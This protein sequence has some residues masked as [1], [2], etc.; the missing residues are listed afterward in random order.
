[1]SLHVFCASGQTHDS[2]FSTYLMVRP[3]QTPEHSPLKFPKSFT[4]WIFWA[5]MTLHGR[6]F[7]GSSLWSFW[8]FSTAPWSSVRRLKGRNCETIALLGEN[9]KEGREGGKGWGKRQLSQDWQTFINVNPSSFWGLPPPL[10]KYFVKGMML[11]KPPG[12]TAASK[13]IRAEP[14]VV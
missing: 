14:H 2:T 3:S 9:M 1:M 4:F 11:G 5:P 6:P 12:G 13:T 10:Q 8:S 7:L